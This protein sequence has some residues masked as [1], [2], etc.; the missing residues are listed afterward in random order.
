MAEKAMSDPMSMVNNIKFWW[1]EIKY[2]AIYCNKYYID[3]IYIITWFLYSPSNKKGI[4][5]ENLLE[6]GMDNF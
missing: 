4:S 6:H 2:K 1:L 3:Y 5:F